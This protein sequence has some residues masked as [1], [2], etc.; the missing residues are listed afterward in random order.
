MP[1]IVEKRGGGNGRSPWGERCL[2]EQATALC[3]RFAFRPVPLNGNQKSLRQVRQ[4]IGPHLAI[5]WP[6][7]LSM[8]IEFGI[9][10]AG[11]YKFKYLNYPGLL[12]HNTVAY[13]K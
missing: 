5:Q 13:I 1:A 4:V 2:N 6:S 10:F 11:S 3:K 7:F 9:I 12:R 8:S